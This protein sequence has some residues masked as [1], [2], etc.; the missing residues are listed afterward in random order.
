MFVCRDEVGRSQI[1]NEGKK[2]RDVKL[3]ACM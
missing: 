2:Q 3:I 1:E